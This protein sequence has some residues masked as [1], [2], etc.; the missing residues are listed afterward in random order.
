LAAIRRPEDATRAKDELTKAGSAEA[1]VI[2]ATGAEVVSFAADHALKDGLLGLLMT[3]ASRLFG[4]EAVYADREL[5]AAHKGAA[6]VAV[7]CPTDTSKMEAWHVLEARH[8]LVA[9]YYASGGID[10]LTG[11][12]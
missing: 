3:G 1:D 5:A 12:K 4:T 2:S 7:H 11:E 8:P 9:R 10:H 6:F